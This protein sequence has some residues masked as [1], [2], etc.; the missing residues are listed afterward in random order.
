M[1]SKILVYDDEGAA[2]TF[3]LCRCLEDYFGRENVNIEKVRAADILRGNALDESV[4]AFFLP[5]G[6]ATPY[7]NK[8]KT[9]GNQK[10]RDYVREGGVYFGICAGAYYAAETVSFEEDIPTLAVRQQCGLD[11][12]RA[13]AVGTLKTDF[14]LPPFD[15]PTAANTA[16]TKILWQADG[17]LHDVVYHGGPKFEDVKDAEVLAVYQEAKGRP[18]AVLMKSFGKGLVIVSGVHFENGAESLEKMMHIKSRQEASVRQNYD[19]LAKGEL[20]RQALI[21]K[22]LQRVGRADK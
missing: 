9:L 15:R 13:H 21:R 19:K 14:G 4:L 11:L 5:G 12:I 2:S 22:L 8:L 17:E 16:V 20:S 1:R 3:E 6:A 18:P 7:M 10:I